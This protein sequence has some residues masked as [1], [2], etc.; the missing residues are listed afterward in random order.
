MTAVDSMPYNLIEEPWIPVRRDDG[1]EEWIHTW[2]LTDH[3]NGAS[4]IVSLNAPRPDF[5]G[6]LI[7]FLIGLVQT[8]FGPQDDRDWRQRLQDPPSPAELREGFSTCKA[9]FDLDGDTPRFLQDYEKI[10]EAKQKPIAYLLVDSPSDNALRQNKDHFVKDRSDESYCQACTATALYSLQTNAPQGGRG[11]RTS[12]RGGGPVSTIVLGRNLWHT[13]W[14]NVLPYTSFGPSNGRSQAHSS[15]VFPWLAATRTSGDGTTTTP[16]DVDSLQ[17]F[18]GMPRRIYLDA[19]DTEVERCNLCG[20]VES[21]LYSEYRTVQHGVNYGGTWEH[22]LTPHWRTDD[23]ELRP[24]HGQQEGFSYRHW[25]GFAVGS[26]DEQAQPARVVRTFYDRTR[27]SSLDP[28][29]EGHP[30]LWVFGFEADRTKIR[31]WHESLMPLFRVSPKVRTA[32]QRHASQLVEVADSDA[33]TLTQALR[34]ALYGYP[35]TTVTGKKTWDF[36][37][38]TGR[39]H[40]F[41]ENAE[42]QFWQETESAFYEVL[43]RGVDSLQQE[44]PLD[45]LKRTW[46]RHLQSVG[47]DLFDETTQYGHFRSTDPK[48]VAIAREELRRFSS[49]RASSIRQTLDLPDPEAEATS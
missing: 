33:N 27:Y 39:D 47:L 32:L 42:V 7:Q 46:A 22:P 17:A 18:W 30:R 9:A 49:P 12:L 20:R 21:P 13:I 40:T 28:V 6:A 35:T 23:G 8:T 3:L 44:Q 5:D 41:F 29:F 10:P 25:R 37:E 34:K 26:E 43:S 4:P 19:P 1:S 2:E 48:A 11:H 15:D 45:D 36:G 16:D 14:L 31:A 38:G 24:I